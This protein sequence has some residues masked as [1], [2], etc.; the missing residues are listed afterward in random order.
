ME[1][2]IAAIERVGGD[3]REALELFELRGS[4]AVEVPGGAHQPLLLE[5]RDLLLAQTIDVHRAARG[6]MLEQL[7]GPL[8]A[9]AV[10]ADR[11]HRVGRLDGRRVAERTALGRPGR[12]GAVLVLGHMGGR[13]DDLGDDVAGAQHD[14]VLA[15][16]DV[17]AEE[18]LLVV[19]R[20][21]ADHDPPDSDRRKHGVG[22]QVPELADVPHDPLEPRDRGRRRELPGDRPAGVPADGAEAALELEVGD[23]DDGPVDLEIKGPA[24]LLPVLAL[25]D[26]L[27]LAAQQLDVRVDPETVLAQPLQGLPVGREGEPFGDPDLVAPHRQ[28]PLRRERGV[29]LADRPRG[30]VAW[31]HERRQALLGPALV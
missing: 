12:R 18:I 24:A 16:A 9:V 31:V 4:Q 22:A 17:L 28:G 23:L 6:E 7:P 3:R 30:R 2:S 25:G 5:E 11:E 29:E 8:G 20:R 1:A 26:D 10:R 27:V 21:Q 13:R 19:E 14:H 15:R